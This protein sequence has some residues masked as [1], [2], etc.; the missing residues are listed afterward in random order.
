M[1][2]SLSSSVI[3]VRAWKTHKEMMQ[4]LE[5]CERHLVLGNQ[6]KDKGAISLAYSPGLLSKDQMRLCVG[7][8]A[9]DTGFE[10]QTIVLEK[11]GLLVIGFERDLVA[12]DIAWARVRFQIPFDTYFREMMYLEAGSI[13]AF[14]EIG[15]SAISLKGEKMWTYT[16]DVL[17]NMTLENH[18]LRLEFMDAPPVV[19]NIESGAVRRS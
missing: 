2:V 5:G 12:I 17:T 14:E 6:E 10:P 7:V 9:A 15:V 18:H 19:V 4:F 13:L 8:F 1:R 16:K 11:A 3:D